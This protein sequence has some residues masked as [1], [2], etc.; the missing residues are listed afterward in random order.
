M[1]TPRVSTKECVLL[2]LNLLK[3]RLS[4]IVKVFNRYHRSCRFER[5]HRA[6][7]TDT[8]LRSAL[9][10]MSLATAMYYGEKNPLKRVSYRTPRIYIAKTVDQRRLQ[11]VFLRYYDQKTGRFSVRHCGI[12]IALT[13]LARVSISWCQKMSTT[14]GNV[15]GYITF[16]KARGGQWDKH[17]AKADGRTKKGGE[18]EFSYLIGKSRREERPDQ[19]Q[20]GTC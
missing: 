9:L 15:C 7:A 2:D 8:S 17:Q 3:S 18:G 6:A 19:A 11:K 4:Q 12:W 14:G 1:S 10:P 13:L 5:L 16:Q 20:S